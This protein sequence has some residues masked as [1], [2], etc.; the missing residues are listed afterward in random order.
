MK[1]IDLEIKK[2]LS[3]EDQAL[4]SHFE[5]LGL[6]SYF[7]SLF[8]GKD[9]WVTILSIF[10]GIILQILFFYSA[11]KFFVTTDTNLKILWGGGAWFSAMMVAFMKV[12]FWMRMESNR[13]IREIKRVELQVA[14]LSLNNA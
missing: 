10:F 5:E 2:A 6:F 11:Y 9:A 12:W 7:K 14:R 4:V 8:R 13:V 3:D 1:D